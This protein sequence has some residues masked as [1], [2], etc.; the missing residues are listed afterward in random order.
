MLTITWLRM[1]MSGK[2][3]PREQVDLGYADLR[4]RIEYLEQA[5]TTK[6]QT[7]AEQA[8]QIAKLTAQGDLS[9]RMLESITAYGT[10]ARSGSGHVASAE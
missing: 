3:V 2:F 8:S 5:N 10:N 9:V 4:A 7:I 1:I 6:D